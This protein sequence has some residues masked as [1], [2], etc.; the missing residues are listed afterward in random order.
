MKHIC[1][2]PVN[3]KC[4]KP[5]FQPLKINRK[6]CSQVLSWELEVPKNHSSQESSKD[7]SW[8]PSFDRSQEP[9]FSDVFFSW[10]IVPNSFC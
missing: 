5:K 7:G 1:T 4:L 6:F 10:S 2:L 3:Q 8:E 9:F